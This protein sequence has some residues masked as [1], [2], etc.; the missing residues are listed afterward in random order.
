MRHK[1]ESV[2]K[3]VFIS[4]SIMQL[5][6]LLACNLVSVTSQSETLVII[7]TDVQNTLLPT[8]TAL[9]LPA[10][11]PVIE[12]MRTIFARGQVLG[13]Q[14]NVFAKVGDSITVSRNFLT[15]FG[16]NNYDLGAY[17]YLQPVIDFY[18]EAR[19]RDNN[20]FANSSLAAGEGWAAWAALDAEMADEKCGSDSPLECEY[21]FLRPAV[22]LIMYGTN[23]VGYR[24]ASDFYADLTQ[25]VAI[26]L[27][28]G[29]IPILSTIP[30]RPDVAENS[31]RFNAIIQQIAE[32]NNLLV[33]DFYSASINLPNF[34]LTHDN[35]HPSAPSGAIGGAFRFRGENLQYGY[36]Q[37]N[38]LA[39]EALHTV[40][41][42]LD[43][44]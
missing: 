34:G 1:G 37:R 5:L 39:L 43:L 26:T 29:I 30:N 12:Q 19:A 13:N 3:R 14:A 23:D 33:M 6:V 8:P 27:D 11:E 20:S 44:P 32:E 41:L 18:S 38:L 7:E 22:A 36:T 4:L 16:L 9:S 10:P 21:R 25:I 2:S 35:V 42:A 40:M 28:K 17:S 15:G 31:L 24:S